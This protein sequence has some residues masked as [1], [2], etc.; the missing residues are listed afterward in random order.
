[1]LNE[2][3]KHDGVAIIVSLILG[4]GLAS[5]FRQ[6]CKGDKCFIVK[7]PSMKE[8]SK[9]IYKMDEK[10]YKYTPTAT[11]CSSQIEK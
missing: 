11:L 2:L 6:V 7:G 10:C 3:M 4:F 5:L 1:M 9:K 8:L